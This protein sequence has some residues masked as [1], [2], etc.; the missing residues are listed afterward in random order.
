MF[1]FDD[2]PFWRVQKEI[3]QVHSHYSKLEYMIKGA[4]KLLGDY[5]PTELCKKLE[6]VVHQKDTTTLE[7]NNAKLASQIAEFK[8]LVAKKDEGFRQ[9]RVQSKKGLDRIWDFNGNPGDVVN[10]ARFFNNDI[11]T[12]GQL[13]APK[14]VAVLVDFGCKMEAMLVEMRK[15]VA[16]LQLEPIRLLIPSLKDTPQKTRPVVEL[17]TLLSQHPGKEPVAEKKVTPT[18]EV[19]A[20]AKMSEREPKTP[21]TTSSNSSP[22][23]ASTMK[24]KKES[25]LEPSTKMEEEGSSEEEEEEDVEMISSRDEPGSK[26]EEEPKPETL[27]LEKKKIKT[28]AFERKKSIPVS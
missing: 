13:S 18:V 9:L 8:V 22:R 19:L 23:E 7:A 20:K 26:G 10:K 15:L 12:E 11:K 6:K 2:N 17:K 4:Y 16:G 25:T 14:I 3:D 5:K 21:K 24:K 28:W 27:P 1:D